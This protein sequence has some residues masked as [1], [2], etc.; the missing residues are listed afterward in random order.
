MDDKKNKYGLTKLLTNIQ[1]ADNVSNNKL[2]Y[3]NPKQ[4]FSK[5]GFV[6]KNQHQL[7]NKII[8]F[9]WCD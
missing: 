2:I 5:Y 1:L 3:I 9:F 7:Y 8:L 4:A 6:S